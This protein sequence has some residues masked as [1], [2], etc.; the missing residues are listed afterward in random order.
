MRGVVVARGE[1]VKFGGHEDKR[2]VEEED[3]LSARGRGIPAGHERRRG[4]SE[5]GNEQEMVALLD[6]FII[7]EAVVTRNGSGADENIIDDEVA[8]RGV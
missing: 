2:N 1:V 6:V 4:Q 8:E 5:C 7:R 3:A